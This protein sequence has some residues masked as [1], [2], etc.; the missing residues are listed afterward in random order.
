M[1]KKLLPLIREKIPLKGK[2]TPKVQ[3]LA[4]ER[5]LSP[6]LLLPIETKSIIMKATP[7]IAKTSK[8]LAIVTAVVY[9]VFLIVNIVLQILLNKHTVKRDELIQKINE[10]AYVEQE[11][12]E[13]SNVVKLY[14]DTKARN[15]DVSES[16]SHISNILEPRVRIDKL[17]F[18]RDD[19]LYEIEA[20]APKATTYA[21]IIT[22]VIDNELVES[23]AIEY[24]AYNRTNNEYRAGLEVKIR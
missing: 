23:I 6:N 11:I 24:V 2:K 3:K 20:A 22:E 5:N 9:G 10:K 16:L 13:V 18:E 19:L 1:L 14:R 21:F 7:K 8:T 17:S 4:Q 12:K 15:Q